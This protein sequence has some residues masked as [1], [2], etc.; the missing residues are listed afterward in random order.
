MSDDLQNLE[1][2]YTRYWGKCVVNILCHEPRPGGEI[3]KFR[4]EDDEGITYSAKKLLRKGVIVDTRGGIQA[5][6]R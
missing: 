3:W 5:N 4:F 2:L 1:D 6:K